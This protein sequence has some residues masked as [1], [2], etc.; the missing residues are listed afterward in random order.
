MKYRPD[1]KE[2]SEI[3]SYSRNERLHYFLTRAVES[4]EVWGLSNQSGWVIREHDNQTI[5]PVW[6]YQIFAAKC[7]TNE[8]QDYTAGAVSLEHFVYK[9]LPVMIAQEIKVEI[10]PS[11]N[12]PGNLLDARELSS[13][14]EGMLE[15]GEYY[16]EG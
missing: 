2:L 12:Q 16:M 8:W 7:A 9:L 4:E 11:T 15:S 1:A 3:E 14:F 6:P 10:L 5:L 13:L